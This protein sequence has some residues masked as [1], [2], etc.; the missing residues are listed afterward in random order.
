MINYLFENLETG[1]EFLVQADSRSKAQEIA[2]MY[3][4][5]PKCYGRVYEDE[6]ERMGIDTY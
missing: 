1:E 6:A 2:Q 3:F 5:N 4:A